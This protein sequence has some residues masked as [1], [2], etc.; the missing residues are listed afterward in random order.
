MTKCTVMEE[1]QE[2]PRPIFKGRGIPQKAKHD[3]M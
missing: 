2:K 3:V 1:E